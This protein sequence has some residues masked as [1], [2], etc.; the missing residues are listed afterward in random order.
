MSTIPTNN[1]NNGNSNSIV[2]FDHLIND[3]DDVQ[4]LFAFFEGITIRVNQ[5][6]VN[7]IIDLISSYNSYIQLLYFVNVF[8]HLKVHI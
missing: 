4:V 7:Y 1:I 3:Q 8:A 5:K 2:S 6:H